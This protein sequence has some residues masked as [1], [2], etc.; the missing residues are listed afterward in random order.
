MLLA[1]HGLYKL[2]IHQWNEN[3]T[4][5]CLYRKG[6]NPYCRFLWIFISLFSS[7]LI[8]RYVVAVATFTAFAVLLF[9]LDK[10]K[11]EEEKILVLRNKGIQMEDQM[12][13][14]SLVVGVPCISEVISR[15]SIR[16]ALVL[17]IRPS[18]LPPL[19]AL[20]PFFGSL[21]D[22]STASSSE[23]CIEIFGRLRPPLKILLEARKCLAGALR[24]RNL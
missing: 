19:S 9:W 3:I 18:P 8:Y 5:I 23:C 1:E 20:L 2:Y 10:T 11:I 24:S 13:P 12:I 15:L 21:N 7:L 17:G 4:E 14:I 16:Y 22:F 6:S